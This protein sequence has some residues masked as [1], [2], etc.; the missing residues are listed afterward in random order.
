MGEPAPFS[1][2]YLGRYLDENR[3]G[4]KGGR[5]KRQNPFIRSGRERESG[6]GEE[7]LSNAFPS[8]RE[9]KKGRAL[10]SAVMMRG[11]CKGGK[12][13]SPSSSYFYPGQ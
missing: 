8:H 13:T 4:K 7:H 2:Q 10:F 9:T 6:K 5:K 3:G 11:E 1:L 12:G